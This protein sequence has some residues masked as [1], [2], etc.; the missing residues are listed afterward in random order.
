MIYYVVHSNTKYYFIYHI[1]L[2]SQQKSKR[3]CQ[4]V[5]KPD[6]V[7]KIQI[8][9]EQSEFIEIFDDQLNEFIL[10]K[11]LQETAQHKYYEIRQIKRA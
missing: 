5:K 3:D 11:R 8:D 10:S 2:Q 4:I 9:Q 1:F 6:K 7:E